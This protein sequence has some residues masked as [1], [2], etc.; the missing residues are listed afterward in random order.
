MLSTG[1]NKIL[2]QRIKRLAAEFETMMEE[3][4]KLD[5]AT[6]RDTTL[7][8]AIRPWALDM[9]AGLRRETN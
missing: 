3:D 9:I 2:Q 1:S 8:L 4:G 6:R 5:T 7:V